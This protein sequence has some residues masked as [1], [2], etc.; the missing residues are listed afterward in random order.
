M[1]GNLGAG[2]LTRFGI[3][4]D[5]TRN[6]LHVEPGPGWDT[7]PFDKNRLGITT[8]FEDGKLKIL[9]VAKSSPAE[10]AGLKP[11]DILEK[12][13][14]TT[15]SEDTWSSSMKK[16]CRAANETP[17]HLCLADGRE[18]HLMLSDYY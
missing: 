16:I 10:Q 1:Q 4:F 5:F 9:H 6:R 17:V 14:G 7:T 11:G 8:N 3:I 12:V 13:N 15:F 18:F 2:I